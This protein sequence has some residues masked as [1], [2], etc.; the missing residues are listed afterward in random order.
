MNPNK[1]INILYED[2]HLII[3]NKPGALLTQCSGKDESNMEDILR[4]WIKINKSKKGNVFLHA[5][6]RIDKQVS[7][8]VLFSKTSK[9]L[10][11]LNEE[12]YRL[13]MKKIYHALIEGNNI[14]SSGRLEN[15]IKHDSFKAVTCT[16]DDKDAKKATLDYKVIE[17]KNNKS[18]L[19][20]NLITGRYHQIRVQLS[21][22]GF[23]VYGDKKYGSNKKLSSIALHHRN[24]IFTHPISNK[25]IDLIAPYP[26]NKYWY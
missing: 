24:F 19:E 23:P 18:K 12:K 1:N 17:F 11:R 2:N 5:C 3:V 4:E 6:H 21:N 10:K 25:E 16:R 9:S 15:Y 20:I 7:G 13:K 22:I 14:K 8:I 26:S